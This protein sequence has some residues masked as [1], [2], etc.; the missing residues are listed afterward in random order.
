MNLQQGRYNKFLL[1]VQQLAQQDFEDKG[2][3]I[4]DE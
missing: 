3:K 1:Q 2:S 4:S